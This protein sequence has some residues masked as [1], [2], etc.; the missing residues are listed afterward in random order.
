MRVGP[1]V[2]QAGA[3]AQLVVT[4]LV[5]NGIDHGEGP[6]TLSVSRKPAGMLVEVHD[7]SSKQPQL[8][9]VNPNSARGRGMQLVQA[10]SA[11]W[12]T[13]PGARGKVVWAELEA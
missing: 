12:G 5:S 11:R 6:I 13:T 1:P 3:D 7:E 10:L 4:E 2:H 8:R 9:P